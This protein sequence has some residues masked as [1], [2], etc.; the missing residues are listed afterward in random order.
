MARIFIW[1][2]ATIL[3]LLIAVAAVLAFRN[4]SVDIT[5]R[6]HT[7]VFDEDARFTAFPTTTD[8]T[9]GSTL[10]YTVVTQELEEQTTVEAT[11]VEE[12][13]ERASGELTV[14]N[15]FSEEPVRL[16]ANTRFETPSGL[17]YRVESPVVVPG[18][19]TADGEEVPGRIDIPVFADEPGEE[20]NIGPVDRF[21]LPGLESEPGDIFENVY[22]RSSSSMT[23]GIDGER[24]RVS[25]EDEE[26]ARSE[27][28]SRL[29]ERIGEALAQATTEGTY[30]FEEL[31]TVEFEPLPP[32][33]GDDGTA[34]VHERAIIRAPA[35]EQEE[36][37]ETI[38]D[39]T[40]ADAGTSEITIPDT[41]TFTARSLIDEGEDGDDEFTLGEDPLDFGLS[42]RIT[43]VWQV[44]RAALTEELAGKERAAFQTIVQTYPGIES[45]EAH[46]RPFWKSTFPSDPTDIVVSVQDPE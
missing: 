25:Q 12:V 43:F 19:Q 9:T 18:M 45:A 22:A 36:F 15:A 17:I 37:V 40:S 26:A 41:D 44:D 32:T 30:V 6:Q 13:E 10:T 34:N 5:P 46:I 8:D 16:V 24:P 35:F 42:G 23:G 31:A 7:V 3:I 20:Y 2:I 28:Q 14:I 33:V 27:L 4:T 21:T 39:S 1:A 29:Q 38:A 11:G